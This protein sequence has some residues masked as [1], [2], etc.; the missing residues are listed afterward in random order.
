MGKK[1]VSN[2]RLEL[3]GGFVVHLDNPLRIVTQESVRGVDFIWMTCPRV[4]GSYLA[5]LDMADKLTEHPCDPDELLC[6]VIEVLSPVWVKSP[7]R[8][9]SVL[10][11]THISLTPQDSGLING[12]YGEDLQIQGFTVA[13][14]QLDRLTGNVFD[15]LCDCGARA[16]RLFGRKVE[17]LMSDMDKRQKGVKSPSLGS[18]R[19]N[20]R[21]SRICV[22]DSLIGFPLDDLTFQ[23]LS[24]VRPS[25]IRVFYDDEILPD[26]ADA[27][28]LT[29]VVSRNLTIVSV[30]QN[31]GLLGRDFTHTLGLAHEAE[32]AG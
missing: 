18:Q 22:L 21:Y 7:Q 32:W 9:S 8:A 12:A 3:S 26:A 31:V 27:W 17:T 1:R 25:S 14:Q 20:L 15:M 19:G 30:D 2:G 11:A 16:V 23:L 6:A 24:V 4:S 5:L 13:R 28:Q 10:V 29:V